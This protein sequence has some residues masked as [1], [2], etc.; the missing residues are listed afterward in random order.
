MAVIALAASYLI[1]A[2]R[3]HFNYPDLAPEPDKCE[4]LVIAYDEKPFATFEDFYPFYLCEH[5]RPATKLF[6]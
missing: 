5:T 3:K 4:K 1:D 2:T 6:Q